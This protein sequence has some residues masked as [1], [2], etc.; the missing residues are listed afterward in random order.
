MR[1]KS[2]SADNNGISAI[3]V[4]VILL[5]AAVAVAGAYIVLKDNNG[6]ESA[7]ETILESKLGIGT[8]LY[9]DA[10]PT[11]GSLTAT[12][13]T[14]GITGELVGENGTHYFFEY[15]DGT[16]SYIIVKIHKETGAIDSASG[17]DGKWVVEIT[18]QNGDVITAEMTLGQLGDYGNIVS[19]ITII[20]NDEEMFF[21]EIRS[22]G[23]KIV[24][25]SEY[26]QSEFFGK[27][28]KYEMYSLM[29]VGIPGVFSVEIEITG[30][31]KT[32]VVGTAADD[33]VIVLIE[34]YMRMDTGGL[35]GED[36]E[37]YFKEYITS[38]DVFKEVPQLPE[39]LLNL[40]Y[41][42]T[43]RITVA[44]KNVQA[45]EYT[46]NASIEGVDVSGTMY[47]STDDRVL[48][49]YDAESSTEGMVFK[50]SV[51]YLEGNL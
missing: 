32:T 20:M 17:V 5:I 18:N 3:V 6:D 31:V 8:I 36:L 12:S 30:N 21:A 42:G 23:H 28:Q 41:E 2:I 26:E 4:V 40:E 13:S 15:G 14:T 39:E 16:D 11:V 33:A 43:K 34:G 47:I 44:G 48:Y 50:I 10:I 1:R 49:L 19:R 45:K 24:E 9:Y 38:E 25:P 29:D 35:L 51:K 7:N 46:F 27:Y 37:F 22:S